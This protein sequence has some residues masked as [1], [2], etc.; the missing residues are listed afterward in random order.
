M[1]VVD[2]IQGT[3][4]LGKGRVLANTKEKQSSSESLKLFYLL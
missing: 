2:G 3:I 4:A 1:V